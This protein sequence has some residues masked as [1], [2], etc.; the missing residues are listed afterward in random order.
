MEIIEFP[1]LKLNAT[2]FEVEDTFH[3]YVRP[4]INPALTPFCI[5][6]TGILQE[7][8]DES[9]KF[10]KVFCDFRQWLL[11]SELVND[12]DVPL[13]R[14]TFA[15]CGDWDLKKILPL[16]CYLTGHEIPRYMREWIN[17]KKSFVDQVKVWP[18]SQKA[19]LTHFG[20]EQQGRS[21]SGIDDCHNL[22][23]V[24]RELGKRERD[25]LYMKLISFFFH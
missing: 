10:H 7:M 24:L 9:D 25:M 22:I 15:T 16:Q 6:L 18:I 12:K 17:V 11:T 1:V 20:I 3:R 19:M 14:F 23:L 5:E 21:H 13:K 4:T 2:T 8:V